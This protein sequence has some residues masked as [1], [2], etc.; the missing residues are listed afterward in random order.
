MSERK[1]NVV[2]FTYE[3]TVDYVVNL[4]TGVVTCEATGELADEYHYL[5]LF[6]EGEFAGEYQTGEHVDPDDEDIIGHAAML[7]GEAFRAGFQPGS[8]EFTK[9]EEAGS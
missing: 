2:S 8:V 7:L 1:P 6:C 3:T 4:D 5:A 9:Y